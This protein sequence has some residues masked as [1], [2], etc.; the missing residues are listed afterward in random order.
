MAAQQAAAPQRSGVGKPLL[1][2]CAIVF[3]LL[4][5]GTAASIYGV[6]W[7]KNKALAK[8]SSYTG[9]VVGSPSETRVAHGNTCSLLSRDDLQQLIGVT[10]EKNVEI[11]EGSAPGCAY[12]TNPAGFEE[13]R[14]LAIAQARKE[15]EAAKDQP[16]TKSDN[17]LSLLKDV[18]QLEGVVKAL[19]LSQGGDKEGRA[20][21]FTIDRNFGSSNWAGLRATT[22][23]V[24]GFQEVPDVGDRA[25]IGAFGH[26][27]YVLKGN[28]LIALEMTWVPD[29]RTRGGD[30]AR[31]IIS[32]F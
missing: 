16:A 10:I 14:N 27:L 17:P 2:G 3:V 22:A 12:Y 25:M 26:A 11:M 4:A 24:P 32:H 5:A 7:F 13:L 6:Y 1:I 18:N 29:A 8:V 30:I 28:S 9:G 31:K 21:A 23:V 20:F 15:A 19:S